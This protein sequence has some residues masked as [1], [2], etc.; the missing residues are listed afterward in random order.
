M[1]HGGPSGSCSIRETERLAGGEA[2][3]VP[4]C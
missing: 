4:R 3:L 1:M 2:R